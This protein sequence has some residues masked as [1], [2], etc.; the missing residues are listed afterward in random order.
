MARKACLPPGRRAAT[1]TLGRRCPAITAGIPHLRVRAGT[2]QVFAFG[3]RRGIHRRYARTAPCDMCDFARA[4]RG[5]RAREPFG[6]RGPGRSHVP[7]YPILRDT[8]NR[9]AW[10]ARRWTKAPPHAFT[11]PLLPSGP[12]GVHASASAGPHGPMPMM[13]G[14]VVCAGAC[15]EGKPLDPTFRSKS[16][17]LARGTQELPERQGSGSGRH[18]HPRG[19]RDVDDLRLARPAAS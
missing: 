13:R 11:L 18:Q 1:E 16:R 4:P 5:R 6:T 14:C 7:R 9:S 17:H 2:G 8:G 19:R 12:G 15:V 3:R 10:P